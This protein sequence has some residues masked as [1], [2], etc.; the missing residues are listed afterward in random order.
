M[1]CKI[2]QFSASSHIFADGRGWEYGFM[3]IYDY[4]PSFNIGF[5]VA[6]L[7][8]D[9]H[10]LYLTQCAL[11]LLVSESGVHFHSVY[12]ALVADRSMNLPIKNQLQNTI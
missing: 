6:L 7:G 12:N 1:T 4:D 3:H 5:H 11:L 9:L 10:L 2:I 8:R